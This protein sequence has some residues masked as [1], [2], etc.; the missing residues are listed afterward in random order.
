M[1]EPERRER[2]EGDRE[3]A[4][5]P[6]STEAELTAD[7]SPLQQQ[8]QTLQAEVGRRQAVAGSAW[9]RDHK[10]VD[11]ARRQDAEERSGGRA[12]PGTTRPAPKRRI[13][14]TESAARALTSSR[15]VPGAAVRLASRKVGASMPGQRKR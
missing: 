8:R 12:A 3:Q 1:E 11:Q 10:V 15:L 5:A 13:R 9:N 7:G 14:P 4:A 6:P 2:R